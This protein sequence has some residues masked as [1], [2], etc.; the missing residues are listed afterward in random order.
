MCYDIK[1]SLESQ[2]TRAKRKG[3]EAA[4][5]EIEQK[6]LPLTNLPIYHASGFS[7]P[8]LFIYT[9]RSPFY[10]EVATWGLV[11]HWVKDQEQRVKLWNNTLNARGETLFEKPSFREAAINQRCLIYI[12]GF[13]EH[14]HHKGQVYP[15]Y[16]YAKNNRPLI[17]AGLW[18]EWEDPK[19]GENMNTFSIVTT[20]GN[21]LLSR[22]HNNPKLAGSRMPLIFQESFEDRW[23]QDIADE[24][25]QKI[26]REQI[27]PYPDDELEAYTVSKLRGKEYMGNVHGIS[28]PKTYE[29]LYEPPQLF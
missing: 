18:N 9:N 10:P 11:P 12:D 29:A 17:L 13:Y 15:Y 5:R 22:I 16:I 26:I 21:S 24:V 8:K 6:L 7:H 23:L 25:D 28:E 20:E 14:H 3:D 19:S 1:A 4:I 27:H 2:L